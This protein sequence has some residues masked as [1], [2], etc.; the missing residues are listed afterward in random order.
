MEKAVLLP[1]KELS[2][3]ALKR[4]SP[5]NVNAIVKDWNHLLDNIDI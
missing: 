2:D 4:I 3:K 1:W 5:F